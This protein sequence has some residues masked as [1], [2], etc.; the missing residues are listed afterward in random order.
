MRERTRA[1]GTPA[2][3][4]R[5]LLEGKVQTFSLGVGTHEVGRV[6][7]AAIRIESPQIS[8]RHAVLRVS[9]TGAALEDLQSVNGTFV[10][11]ERLTGPRNLADGDLVL[12]GN[13][14]F[15]VRFARV[16]PDQPPKGPEK[17]G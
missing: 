2:P 10:N 13:L 16:A 5:V 6:P 3:A 12:F 17:K 14:P 4:L 7:P 9:E 8:R 11:K 1:V 15:R